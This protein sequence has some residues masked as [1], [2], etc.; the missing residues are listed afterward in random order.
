VEAVPPAHSGTPLPSRLRLR[1]VRPAL[2]LS[3]LALLLA[4]AA[5]AS[6]TGPASAPP[7]VGV[8]QSFEGLDQTSGGG[9][10]PPDVQVAAGPGHVVEMVNLAVEIWSTGSTPPAEESTRPLSDLFHSGGDDL[11]DPRV[12]YDALSGRWFAS[13]ADLADGSVLLAVSHDADPT[14]PWQVW[15][16]DAGGA[17]PDQPRLGT[18]DG[19]VVLA[20][21]VFDRCEGRFTR[22]LGAELWAVSKADVLAG[23]ESPARSVVGPLGSYA[24]LTPVHS[25]SATGIEYVVSVDT[26]APSLVHLLAVTGTPPDASLDE[27]ATPA[28]GP[29]SSPP[30]AVE[31]R[32]AGGAIADVRT[33]DTRVLDAVWEQG[34]L[35]LSANTGCTPAGSAKLRACGHVAELATDAGTVSWETDIGYPDADVFFPSVRPDGQGNLVVVYGESSAALAPLVAVVGRMPDGSLTS[36]A[37]VATSVSPAGG[38]NDGRWGDYFGS[39]RDPSSPGLVWVAGETGPPVAGAGDW[40]TAVA[41]VVVGGSGGA[42]PVSPAAHLPGVRARAASGQSGRPLLLSFVA[43]A[44]G[45]GLSRRVTVRSGSSIVFRT[46]TRPAAVAAGHLYGVVWRPAKTTRGSFRFCVR[47]VAGDGR[48]TPASCA[49]V[50]LR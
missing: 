6:G 43:L 44:D 33:N 1:T 49:P 41:A 40:T 45:K 35:W 9:Y 38:Q 12:L 3:A 37:V 24:S 17:C 47:L 13:I 27:V 29:L 22:R 7:A 10:A 28:F 23:V 34:R 31:P 46:T 30:T 42:A 8:V 21:D 26:G 48:Q 36:P 50:R 32:A 16:F 4:P 25:L 19:L 18:S 39:A 20:A 14:G 11:T 15:S 2:A 5:A